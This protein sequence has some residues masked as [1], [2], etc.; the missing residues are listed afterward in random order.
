[1]SAMILMAVGAFNGR[2]NPGMDKGDYFRGI[3]N[4]GKDVIINDCRSQGESVVRYFLEI[5][6]SDE[7][8]DIVMLCSRKTLEM[9][10][11]NGTYKKGNIYSA[12]SYLK[13]RIESSPEKG[14]HKINYK[15]IKLYKNKLPNEHRLQEADDID[16]SIPL[17]PANKEEESFFPEDE[18]GAISRA[19]EYIRYKK[20]QEKKTF[21]LYID[22]HGGLRD[23]VFSMSA[24]NS[25]LYV[26][27]AIRPKLI[28]GINMASARI[29]NQS[30]KFNVFN[31]FSGINEFLHFGN[32][33]I[34]SEYVDIKSDFSYLTGAD[35]SVQKIAKQIV[36]D[37]QKISY[38]V[39]MSDPRAFMEGLK[40]LGNEFDKSSESNLKNTPFGILEQKIKDE[41]GSLLTNP[42]ILDLIIWCVEHGLIQ[43]ALTFV[44]SM[45]PYYYWDKKLLY[46]DKEQLKRFDE[47]EN[48][49]F[50]RYISRFRFNQQKTNK[51]MNFFAYHLLE[52][53][54]EYEVT[55]A[56][57]RSTTLRYYHPESAAK[58][59]DLEAKSRWIYNDNYRNVKLEDFRNKVLP[60]LQSHRI[61]KIIRSSF[62]HGNLEYR[63]SLQKLKRFILNYISELKKAKK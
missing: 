63:V 32:A 19:V 14:K 6:P 23:I 61:L 8:V 2:N 24:V 27:E 33:D 28:S 62:N 5:M 50:N 1:M 54:G 17:M 44:E 31:F 4:D 39:Q 57:P 59:E 49:A 11:R 20:L 51:D 52:N 29:E 58:G 10:E 21:K 37:M 43:Q 30:E 12:V 48:M 16:P 53:T 40:E 25:L 35:P 18:I 3:G 45:L 38:G 41:Y 22:T 56:R 26:G 46:F 42:N 36:K 15:I 34:L 9:D 47:D 60:L 7:E 55:W 13:E